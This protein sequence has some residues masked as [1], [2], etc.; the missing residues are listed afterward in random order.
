M[1]M[2]FVE[3]RC[4]LNR[5]EDRRVYKGHST[6]IASSCLKSVPSQRSALCVFDRAAAAQERRAGRVPPMVGPQTHKAKSRAEEE[7]PRGPCAPGPVVASTGV[8]QGERV[9]S[10]AETLLSFVQEKDAS[11]AQHS[12]RRTGG[13]RSQPRYAS[14]AARG[15]GLALE[16]PRCPG[17]IARS[18]W[19]RSPWLHQPC[20]RRCGARAPQALFARPPALP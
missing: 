6:L 5:K 3:F 7:H 4:I 11:E 19:L 9:R 8:L 15:R 16:M 10:R 2:I 14:G 1:M 13:H 20:P 12:V 18:P 17:R